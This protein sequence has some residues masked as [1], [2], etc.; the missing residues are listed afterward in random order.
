MDDFITDRPSFD[1]YLLNASPVRGSVL[2]KQ[3]KDPCPHGPSSLVWQRQTINK[4][5]NEGG[6]SGAH[7]MVISTMERPKQS[8]EGHL[9]R[10]V[11]AGLEF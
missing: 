5:K 8:K 7:W 2:G 11:V 10:V 1:R 6:N 4:E 3:N 9:E